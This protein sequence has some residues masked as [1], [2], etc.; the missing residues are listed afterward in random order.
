MSYDPDLIPSLPRLLST[1]SSSTSSPSLARAYT[2]TRTEPICATE[3]HSIHIHNPP[4]ELYSSPK[5][6]EGFGMNPSAE[7]LVLFFSPDF[8]KIWLT[9]LCKFKVHSIMTWYIY[10]VKCLQCSQEVTREITSF[11]KLLWPKLL[12][13]YPNP[14]SPCF[15]VHTE[16]HISYCILE[17]VWSWDWVKAH[18]MSAIVIPGLLKTLFALFFVLCSFCYPAERWILGDTR[19]HVL[20]ISRLLSTWCLKRLL[21]QPLHFTTVMWAK[22]KL[23]WCLSHQISL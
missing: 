20:K 23:L 8:T 17:L 6:W 10:T 11:F 22:S 12:A 4:G 14:R 21:C 18:G 1:P 5:H 2:N 19:C 13:R 15:S 9:A 7:P 3:A 16:N